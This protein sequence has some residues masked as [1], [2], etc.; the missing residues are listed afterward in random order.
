MKVIE[1]WSY[2]LGMSQIEIEADIGR[3]AE[4]GNHSKAIGYCKVIDA[5]LIIKKGTQTN[6][7]YIKSETTVEVK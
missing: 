6:N 7:N 4:L 2:P 3:T 1:E 5:V